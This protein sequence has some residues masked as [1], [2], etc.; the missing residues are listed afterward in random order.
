MMGYDPLKIPFIKIAHDRGLGCG[1]VDQI[2]IVGEDVSNV[3]FHFQTQKSPIIIKAKH[4]FHI[5]LYEI[6]FINV[7]Y[8][9]SA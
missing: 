3:N 2:D 9:T 6:R 8:K 4:L 5:L 1:D 7:F